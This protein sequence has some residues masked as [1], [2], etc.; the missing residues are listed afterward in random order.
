MNRDD[1]ARRAI[2]PVSDDDFWKLVEKHHGPLKELAC[3][4]PVSEERIKAFRSQGGAD[5]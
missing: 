4:D 3:D 1:I 5:R 2:R